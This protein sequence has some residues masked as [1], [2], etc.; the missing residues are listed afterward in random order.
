SGDDDIP[1]VR[2]LRLCIRESY[3]FELAQL[4]GRG[5]AD[6]SHQARFEAFAVHRERRGGMRELQRRCGHVALPDTDADRVARIPDLRLRA[7][8]RAP[9]PLRRRQNALTLA[10]DIDAG[11]LTEAEL[12][13]VVVDAVHAHHVRDVP[14]VDV[15]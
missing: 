14:E 12:L 3:R 15:A 10:A 8:E 6:R 1:R 4:A 7:A 13:Q 11:L 5:V 9:L 2:I